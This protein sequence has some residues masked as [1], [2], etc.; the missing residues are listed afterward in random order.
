MA[1]LINNHLKEFINRSHGIEIGT[2][3][4]EIKLNPNQ[5]AIPTQTERHPSY[6][7]YYNSLTCL[8]VLQMTLTRC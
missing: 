8:A 1:I 4:E 7:T 6:N 5:R 2:G 3:T